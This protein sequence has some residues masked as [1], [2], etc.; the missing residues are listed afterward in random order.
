[1]KE[2]IGRG[3]YL[4][5]YCFGGYSLGT[6]NPSLL[7]IQ[8]LPSEWK[9]VFGRLA[10]S[11]YSQVVDGFLHESKALFERIGAMKT[12]FADNRGSFFGI[13]PTLA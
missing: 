9:I 1:M 12:G 6:L 11:D 7:S 8:I 13:L 2:R 3:S 4:G 10:W 5:F